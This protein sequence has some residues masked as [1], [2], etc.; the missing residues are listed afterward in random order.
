L[1]RAKYNSTS[2]QALCIDAQS[3]T[4]DSRGKIDAVDAKF[5][6]NKPNTY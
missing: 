1:S 2:K 6:L 3:L 5:A 4:E